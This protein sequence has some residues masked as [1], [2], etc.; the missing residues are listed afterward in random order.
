[1]QLIDLRILNRLP[2][3]SAT[4]TRLPATSTVCS[5]PLP[6]W[7]ENFIVHLASIY[8]PNLYVELGLYQCTLFNKMIQYA[9]RL[10]GVDIAPDAGKYM[11]KSPK[12]TIVNAST[13]KFAEDV[14]RQRLTIDMMVI[15]AD[16]SKEQVL[17]DFQAFFPFIA[18]HGLILMHDTHPLDYEQTSAGY[19]GTA[20]QA[21]AELSHRTD[22][23]EMVTIPVAPGLTICRKRTKQLSW[24]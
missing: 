11:R 8:R 5:Q 9:Q 15:D 3:L 1:V 22:E 12:T 21:I 7:H 19:C 4:L 2:L 18:P 6:N 24:Q 23:F 10:I 13:R 20:Y 16:H 17:W 14:F